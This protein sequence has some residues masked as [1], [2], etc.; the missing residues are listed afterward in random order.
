MINK[1]TE[2]NAR[3]TAGIRHLGEDGEKCLIWRQNQRDGG[4][5]DGTL[6]GT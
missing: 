6:H 5:K 1:L 2:G 4:K 3:E